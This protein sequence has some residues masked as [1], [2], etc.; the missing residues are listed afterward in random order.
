[1]SIRD[2][3]KYWMNL[4]HPKLFQ[5]L[6]TLP[7]GPVERLL[8]AS[9]EVNRLV[10]GPWRDQTEEHRCGRLS[11]A[12]DMFVEGYRITMA[13]DDPYKKPK[14]TYMARLDPLQD[15]VWEIRV[16]DPKPGI[17]VF[18]RFSEQDSL[19]V[20]T[21]APRES[22]PGSKEWRD[23]REGCKAEWRKLFPTYN[24]ITGNNINEYVSHSAVPV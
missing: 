19:I 15:E 9:K 17:R 24:A 12:T 7:N 22:L 6:P 3:I 20:L 10:V 1:M 14:T 18:G 23:A 8:F 2:E 11:A 4:E 16:L 21:W 13:L 5:V